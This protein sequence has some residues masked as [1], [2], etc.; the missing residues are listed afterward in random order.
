VP[1]FASQILARAGEHSVL[2]ISRFAEDPELTSRKSRHPKNWRM[3]LSKRS[4]YGPAVSQK[5][6]AESASRVISRAS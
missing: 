3:R 5:S 1:G 2:S 6:S 4:A